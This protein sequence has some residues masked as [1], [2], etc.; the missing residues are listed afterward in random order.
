[1]G[2][3]AGIV[4]AAPALGGVSPIGVRYTPAL[5]GVGRRGHAALTFDDGPDPVSTPAVLDTLKTL[6][7]HATFFML[8]EMVRRAPDVARA[9][10]DAG[11]EVAVHGDVHANMLR[12][13][14]RRAAHDITCAF[15]TIGDATGVAPVW[16]RPPFGISSY[17]SMRTARRLGMRTVLW[18]TWGR[19]WR[20]EATPDTVVGDVMRRYVDGGTV[21]LHDS[22][23]TSYPGSWRSTVGALPLLAERLAAQGIEVGTVGE[24]GIGAWRP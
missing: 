22:D 19:D 14:P 3:T 2:V 1:V 5:V 24:H 21:L 7:W 4:H 8:G 20:R 18:T 13:T 11:H 12:R 17:A 23:C 16:F 10:A 9:V 6:G 15:D